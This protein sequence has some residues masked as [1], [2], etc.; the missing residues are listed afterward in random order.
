MLETPDDQSDPRIEQALRLGEL[1]KEVMDRI[2]GPSFESG[3]ENIPM[4]LQEKFWQ[5]ILAFE[6][7]EDTTKIGRNDPAPVAA[8]RNSKN[9][10]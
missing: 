5:H 2:T 9:A 6:A 10:V 3:T 8:A 4:D 7:A 1:R